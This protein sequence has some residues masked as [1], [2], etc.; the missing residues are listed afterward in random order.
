MQ[1]SKTAQL[2]IAIFCVGLFILSSALFVLTKNNVFPIV[3]FLLFLVTFFLKRGQYRIFSLV[4]FAPLF[5][6]FNLYNSSFSSSLFSVGVMIYEGLVVIRFF[7]DRKLDELKKRILQHRIVVLFGMY[8]LLVSVIFLTSFRGLLQC[9]SSISYFLLPMFCLIDLRSLKNKW[10]IV[11]FS[12]G[13]LLANIFAFGFLFVFKSKGVA[14]LE[15]FMP[16]YIKAY[17][18]YSGTFFRFGGLRGDSNGNSLYILFAS[19]LLLTILGKNR[20]T[21]RFVLLLI[22]LL[23]PFAVLG[24]SKSYFIA[25]VILIFGYL[26]MRFYRSKRFP[27]IVLATAFLLFLVL[28]VGYNV[29]YPF[30]RR[31]LMTD[32]RRGFLS[33]V[34][35]ERSDILV[36]YFRII[37]NDPLTFLLG[38]GARSQIL[39]NTDFH[40][41]LLQIIW[42]Y[43]VVGLIL[44]CF[45]YLPRYFDAIKKNN[46]V[47]LSFAVFLLYVLSLHMLDQEGLYIV[48]IC[49]AYVPSGKFGLLKEIQNDKVQFSVVE[50]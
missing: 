22:V 26:T 12:L 21:R 4:F 14:F 43:G 37:I 31:I 36:N 34:T 47:V 15:I 3:N 8:V 6:C 35:T 46:L 10:L 38:R 45:S 41:T 33:G 11:S 32:M 30:L 40:N 29:F 13:I 39:Y 42:D 24:G 25:L 48:F 1:E 5:K 17:T 7:L 18:L 20:K 50:I 9:F 49:L 23:Q 16:S 2:T 27:F 19:S 44:F 28:I